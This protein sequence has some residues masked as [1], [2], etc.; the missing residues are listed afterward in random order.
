M[1]EAQQTLQQ[2]GI[3]IQTE[4]PKDAT[5]YEFLRKDMD[6]PDAVELAIQNRKTHPNE[7]VELWPIDG[8]HR[9]HV[10]REVVK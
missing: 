2:L 9:V 10:V 8:S 7:V 6:W 4:T 5:R 3:G 1:I